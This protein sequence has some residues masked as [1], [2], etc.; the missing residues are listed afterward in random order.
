MNR[1]GQLPEVVLFDLDDTILRFTAG[2]P[3]AWRLALDTCLTDKR[4]VEEMLSSIASLADEFWSDPARA[5]WG[6]LNMFEA[7]RIVA[8][9][10][11]TPYGVSEA[12]ARTIGETMTRTKEDL[13]RPF[14]GAVETLDTLL[15]RGH[16]LG[17]ITNG[18]SEF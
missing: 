2:Q 9:R 10:A 8:E 4:A 11:L 16:R 7:R 3:D 5:H 12:L 18:S 17:L 15:G 6:R 1:R 14:E 13:V